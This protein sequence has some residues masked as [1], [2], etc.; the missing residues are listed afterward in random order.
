VV[1]DGKNVRLRPLQ[2]VEVDKVIHGRSC[3]S[4]D[5]QPSGPPNRRAVLDRIST[6]GQFINGRLDFGICAK[7][8]L[9]GDVTVLTAPFH[10]LLPTVYQVG[11][12]LYKLQDR[13]QGYGSDAMKAL[14]NWLFTGLDA[15][16]V[17]AGTSQGN[18]IAQAM[19][20]R[21]GYYLEGPY[22][23]HFKE[24]SRNYIRYA[25]SNAEWGRPTGS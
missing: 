5:I 4:L 20:R 23:E 12:V 25:V 3:L 24:G 15:T 16:R 6:S 13:A 8:R 17:Q 7:S 10:D 14:T 1:I 11:I 21:I 18:Q 22:Q 9:I 2:E 19:L